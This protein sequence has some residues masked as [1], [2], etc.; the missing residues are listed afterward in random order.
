MCNKNTNE[1][2][3]EI[4]K[5]LQKMIS[6]ISS[7]AG[8][9]GENLEKYYIPEAVY[10]NQNYLRRLASSLQNSGMMHNSIKFNGEN[11][12]HIRKK[13]YDFSIEECLENYSN[14]EE[15]YNAL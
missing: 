2:Y 9:D 6:H 13:L 10:F 3:V 12:D 7:A 4:F 14:Y 15:L 1:L 5:M 8:I 11:F